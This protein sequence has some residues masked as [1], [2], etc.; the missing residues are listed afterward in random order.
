MPIPAA[1]A[2]PRAAIMAVFAAYGSAVGA[3]AGSMPV[4]T[5]AAGIDSMS[6]GLAMTGS[7]L[8]SVIVMSSGGVIARNTSHRAILLAALPLFAL[9][10]FALL[11]SASRPVFFACYILFGIVTGL[12]DI[13]MNAEGAVI[14][15]DMGKPI[16]SAF[17]GSV[18]TGLPVFA[19]VSSFLST[20]AGPWATGL[21]VI[22]SFVIAWGM[23]YRLVPARPLAIGHAARIAALPNKTPLVLLGLAGGLSIAAEMAAI[24]WSAKLLDAQAPGLAAIAGLGAAFF[25]ICNAAIRYPGDALRARFGDL[26]LMMVSILVGVAGFAALGLSHSFAISVL[27]FALVG[28]GTAVLIPCVFTLAAAYVPANRAAGISF[29]SMIAGAPRTLAPWIFGWTASAM[30]ISTAFGLYAGVMAVAL[31]LIAVLRNLRNLR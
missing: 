13:F 10:T 5:K 21:C 26:Q 24:L 19:I 28:L 12:T 23:V 1:L 2:S 8:A 11:T 14:E 3:L 17:H 22:F 18:S 27:A 4:V 25:G 31:V 20:E 7:T 9:L 16:F 15:H 30:G 6:L 29:V